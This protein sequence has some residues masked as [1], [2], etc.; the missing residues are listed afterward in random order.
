MI[1]RSGVAFDLDSNRKEGIETKRTKF[2]EK[3]LSVDAHV[4][5]VPCTVSDSD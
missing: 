3:D 2:G 1:T 4:V 5:S